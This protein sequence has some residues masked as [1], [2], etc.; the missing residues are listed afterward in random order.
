MASNAK[1]AAP[2]AA[3][4]PFVVPDGI[5]VE[6][7]AGAITGQPMYRVVGFNMPFMGTEEGAVQVYQRLNTAYRNGFFTPADHSKP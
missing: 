7:R 1:S 5:D 3:P 6:C 2:I 4:A